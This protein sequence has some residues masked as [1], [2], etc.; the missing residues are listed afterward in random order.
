MG[1]QP[2]E[3][4]HPAAFLNPGTTGSSQKCLPESTPQTSAQSTTWTCRGTPRQGVCPADTPSPTQTSATRGTCGAP[5]LP[6]PPPTVPLFRLRVSPLLPGH[7]TAAKQ[8]LVDRHARNLLYIPFK[9]GVRWPS[10]GGGGYWGHGF[11]SSPSVGPQIPGFRI[12]GFP[13]VRDWPGSE[14]KSTPPT[15]TIK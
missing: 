13:R 8:S 3:F 1:G 7:C 14:M 9:Y 2:A 6:F 15:D 10:T 5:P 12:P 11:I 4:V